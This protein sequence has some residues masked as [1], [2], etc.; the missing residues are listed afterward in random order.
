MRIYYLLRI[1]AVFLAAGCLGISCKKNIAGIT[2][3]NHY[4]GTDFNQV[5]EAF[6]GGVNN[7]YV[8]WSVDTTDW[9]NMYLVYKPMFGQLD[10]HNSVDVRRSFQY[11]SAMTQGFTDSHFQISFFNPTDSDTVVY[12]AAARKKYIAPALPFTYFSQVIPKR[13]FG[14]YYWADS[15]FADTVAGKPHIQHMGLVTAL[16]NSHILYLHLS[17]FYLKHVIQQLG[18]TIL[19]N[20]WN[21]FLT[22]LRDPTVGTRGLIIDMRS[23]NGG[24]LEDLN[25]ITGQMITQPLHFGSTREKSGNGRLDYTPWADAIVTPQ[26]GSVAPKS[27]IV[28]LTD[29][30]SVSMAE[31]TTMALKTLPNTY[32]IGDTTWG[33]NGPLNPNIALYG[34]GQF[35]FA[36]FGYVYTS[37]AMFEYKDGKIYEGK[38][39]PPDLYIPYNKDSVAAGLDPQLDAAIKYLNH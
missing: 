20:G 30:H 11:F 28:V 3:P 36:N 23:N 9:D 19:A 29:Q 21:D 31:L 34:G 22:A 39:F 33:A 26:T 5:F 35:P 6:W 4:P 10:I 2:L 17:G 37:S 32:V 27:P 1:L 18:Y 8:F 25:F 14:T 16:I 24:L 7:N 12:P 13:Y 38:G 15:S